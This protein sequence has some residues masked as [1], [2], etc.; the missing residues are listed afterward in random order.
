MI[1][2]NNLYL[3][4]RLGIVAATR[5]RRCATQ[6]GRPPCSAASSA[7]STYSA[8][9]SNEIDSAYNFTGLDN[10]GDTGAGTTVAIFELEP[11]IHSDIT[12]FESC[13]GI[14][15]AV[16]YIAEDGGPTGTRTGSDQAGVETELDIENVIGLA[17]GVTVDVYQAPNS[18]TGLIDNYTAIVEN[19]AVKVVSTSWGECESESGSSIIS[20][21]S[22]LFEEGATAGQSIFAAAGDD[23]SNDCDA[24]SGQLA[25]DD[26]ASQPY[27]TGVGGTS[28][29]STTA[30]PTE[31]VWNDGGTNGAG[32][33]GISS[34]T[35]C[36]PT[37]PAPRDR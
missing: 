23:G 26:P 37:S 20:E 24:A 13:Y 35:R 30:P 8:Y 2:L 14:S 17:P 3:P 21:E 31:T 1:G 6:G 22:T 12:A 36:P 9:T 25:V 29:T 16:N 32:G 19:S 15:T 27:V 11:N 33:G 5:S 34:R 18:N 10:A 28:L 7:G 4:H